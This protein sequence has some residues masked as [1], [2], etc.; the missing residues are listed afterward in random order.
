MAAAEA[1]EQRVAL[2]RQA[3]SHYKPEVAELGG[4]LTRTQII[5][6]LADLRFDRAHGFIRTVTFDK[7]VRDALV[8]ALRGK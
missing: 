8:L 1:R 3:M 5:E 6:I 4:D 2:A 7:D